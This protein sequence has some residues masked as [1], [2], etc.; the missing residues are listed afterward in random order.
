MDVQKCFD[1]PSKQVVA[2]SSPAAPTTNSLKE[3]GVSNLFDIPGSPEYPQ[4]QFLT[5]LPQ[6]CPQTVRPDLSLGDRYG[7]EF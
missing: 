5:I 4:P 3:Q 6:M 1:L 7:R 2:G